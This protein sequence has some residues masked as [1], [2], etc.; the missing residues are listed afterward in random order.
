MAWMVPTTVPSAPYPM[1]V[2][3]GE[4]GVCAG[5]QPQNRPSARTVG[6]ISPAAV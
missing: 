4:P 2:G 1:R 3:R 5:N 6:R